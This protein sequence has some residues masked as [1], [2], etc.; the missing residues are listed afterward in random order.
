MSIKVF[1]ERERESLG[2]SF[3][4]RCD[5]MM[6]KDEKAVIA[7]MQSGDFEAS[8]DVLEGILAVSMMA[9]NPLEEL[10]IFAGGIIWMAT[11]MH[12]VLCEHGKVEY[13]VKKDTMRPFLSDFAHFVVASGFDEW[14]RSVTIDR[15]VREGNRKANQYTLDLMYAMLKTMRAETKVE[16]DVS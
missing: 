7:A 4:A 5:M 10:G 13:G 8:M 9:E 2:M 12:T 14:K 16:G 1:S 3:D 11:Y 6:K 15:E